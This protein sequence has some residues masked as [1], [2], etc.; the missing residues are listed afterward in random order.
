MNRTSSV[1]SKQGSKDSSHY[2]EIIAQKESADDDA[3]VEMVEGK[4]PRKKLRILVFLWTF[5]PYR[6]V[7]GELMTID[8]LKY[9]RARGH[10]ITVYAKQVPKAYT[11]DGFDIERS[12]YLRRDIAENYDVLITHAEIR[13][14]VMS[15]VRTLPYVSIVHNVSGPTIRSLDRQ[16]PTLTIANSDYTES[17]IPIAAKEHALGVHVVRPPVV[18][19]PLDGPH[20]RIG[21]VNFSIEKGGDVLKYVAERNPEI[22]FLAVTGGH[23]LQV[24]QYS[25]PRN[26]EV[27]PQTPDM[28]PLYAR[29]RALMF[30]TRSETYGKVAAE[31]TQFGIPLIVSD[32]PALHEVCKDAG[33]YLESHRYAEWSEE[34]KRIATD[35]KYYRRWSKLSSER[36]RQLR[37]Q[38]ARDMREFEDLVIRASEYQ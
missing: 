19:E 38:S 13:T 15:H 24:D 16:P 32:I 37:E 11:Y 3:I 14:S 6:Y 8:L 20:D 31:A 4:G 35:E 1:R 33:I 2:E 25:L 7:G 9:L 36:G 26:V 12:V 17:F 10:E 21:I 30:P 27:Q 28:R 5:P 23:G 22:D 18:I 34:V 29:M